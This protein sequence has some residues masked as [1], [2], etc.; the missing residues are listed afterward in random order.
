[1]ETQL[2]EQLRGMV[3]IARSLDTLIFYLVTL[4]FAACMFLLMGRKNKHRGE[5]KND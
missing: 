2:Y 5:K 1:M 3:R 4:F